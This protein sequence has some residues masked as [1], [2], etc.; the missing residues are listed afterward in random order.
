MAFSLA[1][2]KNLIKR[3][4]LGERPFLV[5]EKFMVSNAPAPCILL[6]HDVDR[7]PHRAIAMARLEREFGVGATYYF[8][9]SEKGKFPEYA[10]REVSDL[11]HEVGYH[12]ECLSNCAGDWEKA[13]REFE[14]NLEQFR[15]IAPCKTVSMHGKPLSQFNNLDLLKN[16]DLAN[17]ELVGDAVLYF[18]Q[19]DPVYITDT[20]GVWSSVHNLRDRVGSF[21]GEK[22][23]LNSKLIANWLKDNP[24]VLYISAH[25]ERWPKSRLGVIQSCLQDFILNLVKKFIQSV[26]RFF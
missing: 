13:L 8:R 5:M 22:P 4:Q 10:I 26:R 7:L 12:Y 16:V 21:S 25:P 23:E 11:G 2:Y 17:Y 18:N 15:K 20:G 14:T 3:L 9:C 1:A 6:R 19:L 24:A